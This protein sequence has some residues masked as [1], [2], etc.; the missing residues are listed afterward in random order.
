MNVVAEKVCILVIIYGKELVDSTTLSSLLKFDCSLF[1][2]VVINNGP[3]AL[4]DRDFF[5]H[6]LSASFRSLSC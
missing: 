5:Y 4:S 2:L 6:D 1:D 3:E